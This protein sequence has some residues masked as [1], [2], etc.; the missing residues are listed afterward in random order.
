MINLLVHVTYIVVYS[1]YNGT[2]TNCNRKCDIK[3]DIKYDRNCTR[4]YEKRHE[5]SMILFISINCK[6][7][8]I[9]VIS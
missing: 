9:C 7:Y 8:I 4:K 5:S 1:Y 6:L 2:G 3:Y